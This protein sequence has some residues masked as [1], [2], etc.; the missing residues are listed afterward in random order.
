MWTGITIAIVV[1]TLT[2]V[3]MRLHPGRV[4]L[5]WANPD[6]NVPHGTPY[7]IQMSVS[8]GAEVYLALLILAPIIGAILG[9]AF[10][11]V[12]VSVATNP[13]ARPSSA[14]ALSP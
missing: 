3:M 2:L 13:P 1:T 8:D 12:R 6:P 7:E 11:R 10:S 4:P 9:A 5:K 14:P